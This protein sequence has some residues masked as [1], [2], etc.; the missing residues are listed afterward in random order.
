VL[1]FPIRQF[2]EFHPGKRVPWVFKRSNAELIIP[3]R[4]T[5]FWRDGECEDVLIPN[6]ARPIY[7]SERGR[8]ILLFLSVF[9]VSSLWLR[10]RGT[11]LG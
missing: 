7:R 11:S 6:A 10:R 2:E 5:T 9:S 3:S 1:C 4:R 8:E